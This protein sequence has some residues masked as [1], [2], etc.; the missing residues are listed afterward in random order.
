MLTSVFIVLVFASTLAQ[1]LF[2]NSRKSLE[3]E[4]S[5]HN[6]GTVYDWDFE[7]TEWLN[8]FRIS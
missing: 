4:S 2:A 7:E 5:E 3:E 1:D 8:P 6:E